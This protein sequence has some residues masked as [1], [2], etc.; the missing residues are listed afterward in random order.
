[1]L[2]GCVC[3]KMALLLS[4]SPWNGTEQRS[5]LNLDNNIRQG[6]FPLNCGCCLVCLAK[7]YPKKLSLSLHSLLSWHGLLPKE[8]STEFFEIRFVHLPRLGP[9]VRQ[10][11]GATRVAF[12]GIHRETN[13]FSR[14]YQF[15]VQISAIATCSVLCP[16]ISN[17]SSR[18]RENVMLLQCLE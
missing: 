3:E 5:K 16:W 13:G 2:Q 9:H 7:K 10:D 17:H 6:T 8:W 18:E 4:P 1:M 12:T 11:L 14:H 15:P